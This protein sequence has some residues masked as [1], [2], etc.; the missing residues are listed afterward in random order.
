MKGYCVAYFFLLALLSVVSA[1]SGG[2]DRRFAPQQYHDRRELGMSGTLLPRDAYYGSYRDPAL[3]YARALR[4]AKLEAYIRRDLARREI[5][6]RRRGTGGA[7]GLAR[8][9]T[10]PVK[11]LAIQARM[12]VLKNSKYR[13]EFLQ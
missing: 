4:R 2:F 5:A 1:R 7:G 13:A 8:V 6:L 9:I 10:V 12:Y 11:E 3:I